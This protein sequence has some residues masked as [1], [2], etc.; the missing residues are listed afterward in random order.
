MNIQST[1]SWNEHRRPVSFETCCQWVLLDVQITTLLFTFTVQK[2]IYPSA[3][4]FIIWR[5]ILKMQL[6]G[7][8]PKREGEANRN[9]QRP[10]LPPLPPPS[11]WQLVQKSQNIILEEKIY[12]PNQGSNPHPVNTNIGDKFA[13]H[14]TSS[15]SHWTTTYWL[16]QWFRRGCVYAC[17]ER[18]IPWRPQHQRVGP[19]LLALHHGHLPQAEQEQLQGEGGRGH[20]R[21]ALAY[22]LLR[23]RWRWGKKTQNGTLSQHLPDL[24][25]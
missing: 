10:S 3:I 20:Q 24:S 6:N 23:W 14:N 8:L 15:L 9:T 13:D 2:Y 25:K 12:R 5:R 16:P 22:L 1:S 4:Y 19:A 7:P 21:S 17:T 18:R 11:P